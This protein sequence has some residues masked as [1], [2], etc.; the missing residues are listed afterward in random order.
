GRSYNRVMETVLQ[1]V[2]L[3]L[4]KL[5]HR[6]AFA[7]L[8]IGTLALGI[9]ANT[10]IFSVIDRVLLQ[11]LPYSQPDRLVRLQIKFRDG[12][13]Q[14]VS[15]PKF[16][17]WKQHTDVFEAMCASDFSGPGL[18][19]SGGATPEQVKAIH[20]SADFFPVFDATTT[21]GRV[22]GAEEDR[23]GGPRLAV[24]THGLW[25]RRFGGDPSVVGRVIVLDGEPYTVTG[26]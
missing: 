2:R 18:N 5:T 19:L 16:L 25:V 11:P 9:G 23:P 17:A 6:P 24:M 12:F 4:R 13:G 1:D 10:A 22:F 3:A 26:V 14:S 8:A 7:G 15:I 21:L 20:V